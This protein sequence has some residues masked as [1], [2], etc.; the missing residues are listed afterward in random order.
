MS[1]LLLGVEGVFRI[2]NAYW[3]LIPREVLIALL[4][5][6]V[7]D[8]ARFVLKS[9]PF[10]W[11]KRDYALV[12]QH[13]FV[14]AHMHLSL[15]L[16]SDG[17]SHSVRLAVVKGFTFLLDN[18]QALSFLKKLLPNL[19][20]MIHD[21]ATAVRAAFVKLLLTVKGVRDIKVC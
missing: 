18:H 12:L 14:W 11:D 2:A 17:T 16:S 10:H 4:S 5:T 6:I 1:G 19:K 8:M 13:L 20:Q 15:F 3:E 9:F 21:P 7:Q